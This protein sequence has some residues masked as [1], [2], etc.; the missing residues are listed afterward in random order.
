MQHAVVELFSKSMIAEWLCCCLQR[1]DKERIVFHVHVG[2]ANEEL[3]ACSMPVSL[4]E[5]PEERRRELFDPSISGA[6]GSLAKAMIEDHVLKKE[7]GKKIKGRAA[8]HSIFGRPHRCRR[9]LLDRSTLGE[10]WGS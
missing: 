8:R 9:E 4:T 3:T 10:W 7:L 1:D 2:L 6:K 5:R